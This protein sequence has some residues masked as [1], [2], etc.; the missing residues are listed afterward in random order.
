[1]GKENNT[2]EILLKLRNKTG[3]HMRAISLFVMQARRYPC[4]ITVERDGKVADGKSIIS[5]MTLGA[6]EGS[7][8]RIA[9][10]GDGA[11]QAIEKLK[12]LIENKFGEK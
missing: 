7:L 1:M 10:R 8:L 3:L 4:K 9:A 11:H 2:A 12:E 6:E 5:L